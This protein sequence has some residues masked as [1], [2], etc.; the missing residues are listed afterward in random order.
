MAYCTIE[1][2]RQVLVGARGQDENLNA[3]SLDDDQI[4]FAIADADS[5]IDGVLR[6][7]YVIPITILGAT[8]AEVPTLIHSVSV[9]LSVYNAYLIY[10]QDREFQ[11]PL[12]AVILRYRKA[13]DILS[14]IDKG[15]ITLEIDTLASVSGADTTSVFNQYD[16]P[17]FPSANIFNAPE[18]TIPP[19]WRHR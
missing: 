12:A 3:N 7:K 13:A 4:E 1:E 5:D 6:N 9:N 11:S 16:G 15:D 8:P 17:L 18:G 2:V 14:K 19:D 10:R